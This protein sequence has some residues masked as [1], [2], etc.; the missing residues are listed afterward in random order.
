MVENLKCPNCTTREFLT[1][2]QIGKIER[3]IG[4]D[5]A[6]MEEVY[7]DEDKYEHKFICKHCSLI[8]YTTSELF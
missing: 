2:L 6:E 4:Y 7:Y 1:Q 5:G 3:L 8:L